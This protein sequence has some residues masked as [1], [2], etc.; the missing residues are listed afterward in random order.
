[1]ILHIMDIVLLNVIRNWMN[2][3]NGRWK[4]TKSCIIFLKFCQT[5]TVLLWLYSYDS[6]VITNP[7]HVLFVMCSLFVSLETR[8]LI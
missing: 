8:L 1:M 5:I 7:F 2:D 3:I 6:M 4:D